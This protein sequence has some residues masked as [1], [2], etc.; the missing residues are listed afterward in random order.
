[1]IVFRQR[2]EVEGHGQFPVDMLRYDACFP[3]SEI[4]SGKIDRSLDG[5]SIGTWRVR[6]MR[7]VWRKSDVPTSDRWKS[8]L[9]K[10]DPATI[11][12]ERM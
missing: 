10:V 8:F 9:V 4:D 1:M 2:F 7:F 3:D 6:L 11:Q 12:T 5:S